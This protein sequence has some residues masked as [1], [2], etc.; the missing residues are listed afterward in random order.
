MNLVILTSFLLMVFGFFTVF[1]ISLAD[2]INDIFIFFENKKHNS[3]G[4]KIKLANIPTK[5]ISS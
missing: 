2:T 4:K 5:K 3:L 1:E